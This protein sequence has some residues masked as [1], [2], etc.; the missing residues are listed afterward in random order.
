M[1]HSAEILND[2]P[3][4]Q[5]R[6]T[7]FVE[8]G[9]PQCSACGW[10][11]EPVKPEADRFAVYQQ[12]RV[13]DC[14]RCAR[15]TAYNTAAGHIACR[16]CGYTGTDKQPASSRVPLGGGV[17]VD[18]DIEQCRLSDTRRGEPGG[19]SSKSYKQDKLKF[20]RLTPLVDD[21]TFG[22]KANNLDPKSQVIRVRG[23]EV[24]SEEAAEAL[25]EMIER[26]LG[27]EQ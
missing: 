10:M 3:L 1:T 16:E 17:W 18:R 7:F 20:V 15:P 8:R 4:C 11:D 9:R 23:V 26:E 2:C 13:F 24:S 12:A 25:R 22:K 21:S 6:Q 14:P 19:S 5:R 27:G